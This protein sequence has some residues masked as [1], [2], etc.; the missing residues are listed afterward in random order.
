MNSD[1]QIKAGKIT[2]LVSF[3]IGTTIFGFYFWTSSSELLFIGYGFF[4]LAGFINLVILGTIIIL[5]F[6]ENTNKKRLFLT[7][8]LMLLNIPVM[9]FYCSIAFVLLGTMRITFTNATDKIL[10]DINIIGCEPKH[11][12]KLEIGET[13][14]VWVGI[15]GDCTINI[16]YFV[17]GERKE[18]NVV[19][20]VTSSMGQKMKHN[21]GGHNDNIF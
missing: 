12:D 10:T 16:D 11:I 2:A 14:T 1:K 9:L 20:Y 18:E 3:L 7:S 6:K 15:T 4:L 13:K 17:D 19:G 8:G 5:L 21:I